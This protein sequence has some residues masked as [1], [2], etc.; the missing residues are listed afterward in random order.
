MTVQ[1]FKSIFRRRRQASAKPVAP[2]H[3]NGRGAVFDGLKTD[4][5]IAWTVL[6]HPDGYLREA[7]LKA[8][9]G[10]ITLSSELLGIA[11]RLNDWVPEVRA[12]ALDAT[13][14]LFPTAGP[15]VVEEAAP[16]LLS[17]W[18]AW[19]RWDSDGV[20]AVDALVGQP[21]IIN[22]IIHSLENKRSRIVSWQ[23]VHLLRHDWIDAYLPHLA[24]FAVQPPVRKL[25]FATVLQGEAK[26]R[27]RFVRSAEEIKYSIDK[28]TVVFESRPLAASVDRTVLVERGLRD[29]FAAVRWLA[30]GA[31]VENLVEISDRERTIT[32]LLTDKSH[33]VRERGKF[34]ARREGI[35]FDS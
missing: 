26:W 1:F 24:Q 29:R 18:G 32:R 13:Q 21:E 19:Q 23:F 2:R 4:P 9:T 35:P 25:A 3:Q 17:R 20:A 14:R 31:L 30:A 8:L 11:E 33:S 6:Q 27:S 7:A 28:S 22:R 12:A 5:S 10:P 34:L 16:Y 15:D